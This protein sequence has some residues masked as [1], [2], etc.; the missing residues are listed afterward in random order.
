VSIS[1]AVIDLEASDEHSMSDSTSSHPTSSHVEPVSAVIGRYLQKATTA[2]PTI[3]HFFKPKQPENCHAAK[4]SD[5]D[6]ERDGTV[7]D[8]DGTLNKDD[9]VIMISEDE[10]LCDKPES[11]VLGAQGSSYVARNTGKSA[12]K[13]LS[14]GKM[15]AGKKHKQFSIQALFAARN[16]QKQPSVMQCPICSRIFDENVSNAEVNK[17][18]DNC[19]IE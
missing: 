1:P 8:D 10:K 9:V 19:L 15:P 16:P 2:P 7:A 18:I 11:G 13:R 5:C 6:P 12:T 4:S 17:H 3:R 14:R